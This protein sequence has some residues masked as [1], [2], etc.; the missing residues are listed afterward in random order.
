MIKIVLQSLARRITSIIKYTNTNQPS[1]HQKKQQLLETIASKIKI[2]LKPA[3]FI[4][5][6]DHKTRKLSHQ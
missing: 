4:S 6:E 1:H 5:D 2:D 3:I